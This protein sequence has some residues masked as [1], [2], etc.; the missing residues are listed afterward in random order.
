[1]AGSLRTL[2]AQGCGRVVRLSA[3]FR[4]SV[5]VLTAGILVGCGL[6]S[7]SRTSVVVPGAGQVVVRDGDTVYSLADT[8]G[9]PLRELIEAN[10]LQPP[11][12]LRPGDILVMPPSRHHVVLQGENLTQ[13]ARRYQTS[14][15]TLVQLNRLESPDRIQ[16]GQRLRLPE[17]ESDRDRGT[18]VAAAAQT[19]SP[20]GVPVRLPSEPQSPPPAVTTPADAASRAGRPTRLAPRQV[21]G[22]ETEVLSP[23]GT[24]GADAVSRAAAD[25]SAAN[26]AAE[27]AD[28]TPTEA[29]PADEG[30]ETSAPTELAQP[31]TTE[32]AETDSGASASQPAVPRPAAPPTRLTTPSPADSETL[33]EAAPTAVA[34]SAA[35]GSAD[36][37]E[38]P[39][40]PVAVA[41]VPDP[42]PIATA[43]PPSDPQTDGVEFRW[44]VDGAVVN[45]FGPTG[46]DGFSDG[47]G[48]AAETGTPILAAADGT[49][50]Y[51]G[52]ELRGYGNLLLI[53]HQEG[54]VTAY[55][56]TDRMLVERG[57]N[58]LAGQVIATVGNSGSVS[59]PKLH[60][61]IRQ[62]SDA[63]D[64][65]DHLP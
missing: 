60:F 55:A 30:P 35:T 6:T 17:D 39:E 54:W 2:T 1:M 59:E 53:R 19:G 47:I 43:T 27:P 11:F 20:A 37:P 40:A 24:D 32:P 8:Y 26:I 36:P 51:A 58:V 16:A 9:V 5:L 42:P 12:A 65:L 44:P 31:G 33:P 7:P 50:A 14:V 10:A 28:P 46:D 25:D 45:R 23:G 56:H 22:I 61:E 52:N 49:V 41:A 4:L 63:V 18:L 62:G 38:A 48:I 13:I 57:D 21:A 3:L 29:G 64:P 34:D 15:D